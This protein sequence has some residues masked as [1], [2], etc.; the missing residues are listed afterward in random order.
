MTGLLSKN[1]LRLLGLFYTNP[2]RSFYMQE[3]GRI[4]GKKPGVFQRTLNAL[5][6]AGFLHSEYRGHARFFRANPRHP[7]YPE[8]KRLVAKTAGVEGS[9]RHLVERLAGVKLAFLYGSFAKGRERSESDVDLLVV[10][11]PRMEGALV[12]ALARLETTLQR[13]INYK[14]YS[15]REYRAKRAKRD[16]FLQEILTD[17]VV[18]LKGAPDAV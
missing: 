4:L 16:P 13:E 3:L 10:G 6:E 2:K 9:L 11:S 12:H 5:A 14:F 18:V 8:L 1:R 15:E 17:A 7:L